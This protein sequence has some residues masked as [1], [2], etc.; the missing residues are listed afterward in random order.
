MGGAGVADQACHHIRHAYRQAYNQEHHREQEP[1][2]LQTDG[3]IGLIDR[4]EIS[5][6]AI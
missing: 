3:G 6:D 5:E 4:I 1:Q 2:V